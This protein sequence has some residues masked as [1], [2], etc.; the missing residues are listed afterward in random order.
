MPIRSKV[1]PT[2]EETKG[3]KRY[4][5]SRQQQYIKGGILGRL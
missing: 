3:G 5:V 4:G 2:Q 1:V